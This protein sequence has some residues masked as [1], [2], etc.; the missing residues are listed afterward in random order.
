MEKLTIEATEN[1]DSLMLLPE[2]NDTNEIQNSETYSTEEEVGDIY[3][4]Y[5]AYDAEED[6]QNG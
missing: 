6:E 5:D 2:D 1:Q 3:D 4:N